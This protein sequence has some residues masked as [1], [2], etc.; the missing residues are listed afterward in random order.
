MPQ[1]DS[2]TDHPRRAPCPR[3][4]WRA[5]PVLLLLALSGCGVLPF[6]GYTNVDGKQPGSPSDFAGAGRGR[7]TLH[8]PPAAR[9]APKTLFLLALSGGGSRAAYW[10]A[11]TMFALQERAG[12]RTPHGRDLLAEVD[13]LSSVSGGSLTAAYYAISSD[14]PTGG[15]TG[16]VWSRDAVQPRLLKNYRLRW[17]GNWFWPHNAARF[18][19]THFDRT[20]IMAQTLADNLFDAKRRDLHVGQDFAIKDLRAERPYLI[21]NSTNVSR[22]K[23][24]DPDKDGKANEHFAQSFTFTTEDFATIGSNLEEYSLARAVMASATFPGVFNTMTLRDYTAGDSA[25]RRYVHLF[26]GGN[27]DNLG[28]N[29]LIRVLRSLSDEERRE[30]NLVVLVVDAF[31]DHSGVSGSRADPRDFADFIVDDNF[32]DATD[33]LLGLNRKRLLRDLRRAMEDA[34]PAPEH[35][36][37]YHLT[38]DALKRSGDAGD[39]DLLE[40]L[41]GI[42]TDFALSEAHAAALDRAARTLLSEDNPCLAGIE[43]LIATG[44]SAPGLSDCT[45]P[46]A[47]DEPSTP[48]AVP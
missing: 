14:D 28:V 46:A 1:T 18:W 31:V 33:A 30:L 22:N 27:S 6:Y 41:N 29:S 4:A 2:A 26:D 8:I 35:R 12:A 7:A 44:S 45:W 19:F 17:F 40:S 25:R 3:G 16:R 20:D 9:G 23:T 32:L 48:A 43:T 42:P 37:L 34:V 47:T 21:L 15:A 36:I 39:Q 10:S 38:F 5:L 13:G 24:R 11:A